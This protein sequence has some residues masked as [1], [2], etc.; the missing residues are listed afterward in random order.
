MDGGERTVVAGGHG[1]DHVERFAAADFT[2]DDAV[3]PHAEGGDEEVADG[4]LAA[5][6]G[7]GSAG[8]H[9]HDVG[10]LHL[11]FARVF[12]DDNTFVMADG[13]AKDVD[14]GGFA[15]ARAAGDDDVAVRFDAELEK[16]EGHGGDC[17]LAEQEFRG[18]GVECEAAD[19]DARSRGSDF[20][21]H[22]AD[23]R[24][25]GEAA[26][27]QRA[28]VRQRL[29]DELRDVVR[30]GFDVGFRGEGCAK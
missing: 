16:F 6:I 24:A 11:E 23:A 4:D 3:G 21:E 20:A 19:V 27:E 18:G 7:V 5:A 26:I 17:F 29:T 9:L 15:G 2:H 14:G 30:G 25:I 12:D 8:L 10:A 13:A 1:L 28:F 22:D